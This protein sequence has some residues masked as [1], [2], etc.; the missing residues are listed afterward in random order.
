MQCVRLAQI[1]SFVTEEKGLHPFFAKPTQ[2]ASPVFT[3]PRGKSRLFSGNINEK[4]YQTNATHSTVLNIETLS[5]SSSSSSSTVTAASAI[6]YAG[7]MNKR[8]VLVLLLCCS[9]SSSL[10]DDRANAL[11]CS[12]SLDFIFSQTSSG[13]P[14]VL[15]NPNVFRTL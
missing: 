11:H 3:L 7:S 10:S 13:L 2:Y 15:Y 4:Q 6:L 9:S 5:S 8:V 1:L 14:A 12:H